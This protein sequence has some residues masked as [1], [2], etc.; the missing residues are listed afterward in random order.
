MYFYRG[1]FGLPYIKTAQ[2]DVLGF[3]F[4]FSP[5]GCLPRPRLSW[6]AVIGY[7]LWHVQTEFQT[8]ALI[9]WNRSTSV[10]SPPLPR[11]RTGSTWLRPWGAFSAQ[12]RY[13]IIEETT[14]CIIILCLLMVNIF[15]NV[16]LCLDRMPCR[17]CSGGNFTG[18]FR[19]LCRSVLAA[20][21]LTLAKANTPN[22]FFSLPL[23]VFIC[24]YNQRVKCQS[25]AGSGY[26]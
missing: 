16:C 14:P 22:C 25:I 4:L 20:S 19:P 15:Y 2:D 17:L 23:S 18:V 12:E 26:C 6:A 7:V 10:E 9:G 8:A 3:C 11:Q 1:R 5:P 13:G 24:C 21:R